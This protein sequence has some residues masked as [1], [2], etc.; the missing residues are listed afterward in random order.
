M[1]RSRFPLTAL[2]S[3]EA[4]GRHES[5]T[6]A[7]QELYVSQAAIS[8]QVRELE[9]L[10]GQKLFDRLHKRV[11]LTAAGA[12]LLSV[13]TRS[14]NSID[15]CLSDLAGDRFT[16]ALRV[17]VEPG[18]A[19][20][21]LIPHLKDFRE[22]HPTIDVA[23]ESEARVIDFNSHEAQISIRFGTSPEKWLN[24]TS[25]HIFDSDMVAV[26][27][28]RLLETGSFLKEPCDLLKY[29]LLHE[30]NRENWKQ[31]FSIAAVTAYEIERG[32]IYTDGAMIL[33]AVLDNQGVGIVEKKFATEHI[34]SGRLLQPFDISLRHG[35]YWLVA[36]NFANLSKPATIFTDWVK[37]HID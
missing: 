32:P 33:Q 3:F 14:F 23:V 20:C 6:L 9:N 37:S 25:L 24:S 10:L 35:A 22:F 8:R 12:R 1:K 30:D 31:W 16:S 7:S 11:N 21:W 19:S 36:R 26:I 4:A 27:S 15:T 5:F 2:R 29:T 18:F 17:S 28:Q 13:L 34:K